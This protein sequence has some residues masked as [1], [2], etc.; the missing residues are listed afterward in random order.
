MPPFSSFFTVLS[1]S[2]L[3]FPPPSWISPA[4]AHQELLWWWFC[5]VTTLLHSLIGCN[6]VGARTTSALPISSVYSALNLAISLQE[7]YCKIHVCP[8]RKDSKAILYLKAE[9]TG[10]KQPSVGQG[11]KEVKT[12]KHCSLAGG[13]CGLDRSRLQAWRMET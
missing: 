11:R 13:F 7:T 1:W 5:F 9:T 6:A 3:H 8:G 2:R 4:I 10:R 12:S